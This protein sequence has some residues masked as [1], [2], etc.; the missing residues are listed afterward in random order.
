[1]LES[2]KIW[3]TMQLSG[4]IKKK[5][6]KASF[7]QIWLHGLINS[8]ISKI[9]N[10]SWYCAVFIIYSFW[11]NVQIFYFQFIYCHLIYVNLHLP[12]S[13]SWLCHQLFPQQKC[14]LR[15]VADFH[16]LLCYLINTE[17][18]SRSL[19]LLKLPDLAL[20]FLINTL[21]LHHVLVIS[22]VCV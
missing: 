11:I 8:R 7:R 19:K 14:A 1:M 18:L 13:S 15:V 10:F 3:I 9:T 16:R 22:I 6:D 5:W 12:Q 17:I 2:A 20:C 4:I 21:P